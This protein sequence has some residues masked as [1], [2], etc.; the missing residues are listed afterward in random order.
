MN[1]NSLLADLVVMAHGAYVAFVVFGLLAILIGYLAQWQWVRNAWFRYAH[2]T[3]ILIVAF[4]ALAGIVCPLTTLENY[5]RGAAGETVQ[6]GSFMAQVV[7]NLL[8][9]EAP[10]WLFTVCYCV[11]AALVLL[12]MII[13]PPRRKL[14]ETP[15]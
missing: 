13:V 7:H 9:Y 3:M 8:F 12:T 10:P 6:S 11:F 2:L 15:N 4:E 14:R 1:V 5:L